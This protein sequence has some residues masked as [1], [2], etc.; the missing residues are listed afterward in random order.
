M[1]FAHAT[2]SRTLLPRLYELR[3]LLA[4]PDARGSLFHGFEGHLKVPSRLTVFAQ[5]ENELEGLDE[6]A[7]SFLKIEA[8]PYLEPRDPGGRGWEQ[9]FNFLV[10][11]RA[12]N[13]LK[14]TVGCSAVRF[15]SRSTTEQRP[16]LEG[17]TASGRVLCE[18]KAINPSDDEIRA[19]E[20]P[21]GRVDGPELPEG[22]FRKLDSDILK[23]KKQLR[24]YDAAGDARHLVFVNICFDDWLGTCAPLYEQQIRQHLSDRPPGVEVFVKIESQATWS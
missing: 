9:L 3:D 1:K 6:E 15:V 8:A 19:R 12:Y 13:H 24:A 21:K 20:E 22:F 7:W 4:N 16:D 5:W 2:M 23:A 14:H 17:V 18:V 10:Q 11:A